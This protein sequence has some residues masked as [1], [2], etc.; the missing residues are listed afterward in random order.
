MKNKQLFLIGVIACAVVA[1]NGE[2][3]HENN[4]N[5]SLSTEEIDHNLET[6]STQE[7]EI[8]V[9]NYTISENR[10]GDFEIG[11]KIPMESET[12][13]IS[14]EIITEATEEGPFEETIYSVSK[15]SEELLQLK[16]QYDYET[17]TYHN[18]ISEMIALSERYKTEEGI[19][20]NSTIEEF[21]NA[22][23]D[24]EIWFT[25]VSGMFVIESPS[26]RAQFLLDGEGFTGKVDAYNDMEILSDSDFKKDTRITKVRMFE[27]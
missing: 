9:I 6:E 24:F 1:C 2:S 15:G 19:G 12:Y 3:E 7:E 22:Y 13:M 10:V 18:N 26:L 4:L 5:D 14:E 27:M 25:Y 8:A 17:D 20:V 16:R 21:M 23:P 11:S